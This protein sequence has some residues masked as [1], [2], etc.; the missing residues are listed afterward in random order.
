M[1]KYIR[2]IAVIIFI[3]VIFF[4]LFPYQFNLNV[5]FAQILLSVAGGYAI[6]LNL[7]A[8]IKERRR[9]A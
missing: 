8:Q 4:I 3:L 2:N 5:G 1:S 9:Q 7:R 6:Y